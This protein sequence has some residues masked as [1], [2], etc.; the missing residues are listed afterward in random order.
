M[1]MITFVENITVQCRGEPPGL[2]DVFC[3]RSR[4][5]SGKAQLIVKARPYREVILLASRRRPSQIAQIK[6]PMKDTSPP[7]VVSGCSSPPIQKP[8]MMRTRPIPATMDNHANPLGTAGLRREPRRASKP[9]NISQTPM[10]AFATSTVRS[11]CSS[12]ATRNTSN[13]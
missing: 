4:K 1:S 2:T 5:I 6:M 7:I 11:V 12:S 9:F 10:I 8:T 13:A 3:P